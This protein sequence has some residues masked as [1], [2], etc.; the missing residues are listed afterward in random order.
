[1]SNHI[2]IVLMEMVGTEGDM[3]AARFERPRLVERDL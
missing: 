1:M 3:Y 2:Y